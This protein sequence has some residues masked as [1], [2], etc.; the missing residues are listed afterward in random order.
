MNHMTYSVAKARQLGAL[1][2]LLSICGAA[3]PQDQPPSRVEMPGIKIGDSWT[4][5]RLDGWTGLKQYSYVTVVTSVNEQEIRTQSGPTSNHATS[6]TTYDKNFNHMVT[7]RGDEKNITDPFYPHYSFPLKVGKT[8]EQEMTFT[9]PSRKGVSWLRGEVLGWEEVNVPAGKFKALKIEVGGAYR[10][11]WQGR[12]D[13][14][15]I[16]D[17]IWYAPEVKT[18]VKRNYETFWYTMKTAHD[19]YELVEYKVSQ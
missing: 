5:N 7:E 10:L 11:L 17:T 4:Y 18:V 14:G 8:W 6:S 12:N 19:V 15:R 13:A 9:R 1:A 16:A 3:L 2:V